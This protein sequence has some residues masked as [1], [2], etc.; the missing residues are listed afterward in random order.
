MKDKQSKDVLS[1]LQTNSPT[2]E[3]LVKSDNFVAKN[4]LENTIPVVEKPIIQPIEKIKE[5]PIVTP[6]KLSPEK[7]L[8]NDMNDILKWNTNGVVVLKRYNEK[9][10]I[11]KKDKPYIDTKTSVVDI[12]SKKWY[13][14]EAHHEEVYIKGEDMMDGTI[15]WQIFMP[16]DKKQTPA[17]LYCNKIEDAIELAHLSAYIHHIDRDQKGDFVK[18]ELNKYNNLAIIPKKDEYEK[19]ILGIDK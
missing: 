16:H 17:P 2:L 9:V 12:R 11:D 8:Q 5:T 18:Q 1:Y 4:P 6:E 10:I 3:E 13:A 7:I 14:I 15:R 19:W